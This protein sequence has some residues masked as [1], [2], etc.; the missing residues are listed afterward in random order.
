MAS[1]AGAYYDPVAKKFFLVMVPSSDLMLDTI[2]AHELTH[3]LQDQHYDLQKYYDPKNPQL[4][5]LGEDAMN[6][7][8]FIVEGDATLTMMAYVVGAMTKRDALAPELRPALEAQLKTLGN[9]GIEQLKAMSKEQQSGF[10]LDEEMK[11]SLDAMDGVP[12]AVML[13]LLESYSRGAL[14][15]FSAHKRGGW[16]EVAKLYTQPPESTEQVL[17][18][19][20]KLYPTRDLPRDISLGKPPAGYQRVHSDTIGEL[21]WRVYFLL[22]NK[23]AK[24][25]SADAASAGWDGDRYAVLRG[26]DGDLLTMLATTWDSEAE[27]E[28]FEA[29]YRKSLA[30]RLGGD[31]SK[32]PDGTPVLV[33]R[34]G[35]DVFLVDGANAEKLMPALLKGTKIK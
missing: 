3:A 23:D 9:M 34:R 29:A 14:P 33:Q 15:I 11:A 18:P 26:K 31:G 30:K 27:A 32:R 10:E 20:T 19:E 5:A 35:A 13:P 24:E 1:Q 4:L 8:R 16:A 2:S 28:E 6:A 22:W 17:H 25:P 21:L 12:L 7:R